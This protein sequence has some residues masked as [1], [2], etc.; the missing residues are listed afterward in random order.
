VTTTKA[1]GKIVRETRAV[2]EEERDNEEDEFGTFNQA[3][4]SHLSDDNF[5]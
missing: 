2:H 5:R 4:H 1:G 3:K